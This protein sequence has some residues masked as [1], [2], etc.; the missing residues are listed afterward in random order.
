MMKQYV[1]YVRIEEGNR[2]V[3]IVFYILKVDIALRRIKNWMTKIKLN[4]V[5][6]IVKNLYIDDS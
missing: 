1:E 3:E 4:N 6:L 2:K 5:V